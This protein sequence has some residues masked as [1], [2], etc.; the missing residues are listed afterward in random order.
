MDDISEEPTLPRPQFTHDFPDT[1]SLSTFGIGEARKKLLRNMTQPPQGHT[2]AGTGN[3][4]Q[5]SED[6][7]TITSLT[8]RVSSLE[9]N[10]DQ[11]LAQNNEILSLL[12]NA[13]GPPAQTHNETAATGTAEEARN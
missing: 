4:E 7:S 2:T 13:K 6:S 9:V 3:P 10:V 11:L 1:S 12:R 5:V 8:S